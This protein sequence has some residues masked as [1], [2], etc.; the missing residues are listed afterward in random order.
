MDLPF[1]M[2]QEISG[3]HNRLIARKYSLKAVKLGKNS[4]SIAG[5]FF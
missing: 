4:T 5:F 3:A 1:V 2:D